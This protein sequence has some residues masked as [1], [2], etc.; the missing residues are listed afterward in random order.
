MNLCYNTEDFDNCVKRLRSK[1]INV[2]VHI[3]NGLP[4]ETKSMML[5][6]IKHINNLDIQ[7][8]KIHSLFVLKGSVLATHFLNNEF[9]IQSL[10][11]YVDIVCDQLSILRDDIV[12]HRISGDPPK[13]LLIE[14]T[15]SLKKFVVMNE[16]D[17]EMKKR[18]YYQG[19]YFNNKM[20][21]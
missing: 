10:N 8:I 19:I 13:D 9:K 18:K 5:D 16:I 17:K 7:G 4:F 21:S 15:W 6:T 1:N 2:V 3:I 12:V 14:P 20:Q 11:E